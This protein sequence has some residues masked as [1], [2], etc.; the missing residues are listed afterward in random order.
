MSKE[1]ARRREAREQ[2]L[3]AAAAV[4][5]AEAE[6]RRRREAR[7]ATLTRLVPTPAAGQSGTLAARRRQATGLVVAGVV[8]LNVLVF[9]G[10]SSWEPR[11]LF[12]LLCLL[13]GPIAAAL[14]TRK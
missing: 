5:A 3:A 7:R 14:I 4:R 10:T 2:E 8:C 6:R 1:R 9:L 13:V 12:L 11:A